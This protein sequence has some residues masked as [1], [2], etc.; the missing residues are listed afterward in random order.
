MCNLILF[1]FGIKFSYSLFKS[2]QV[3]FL[4][5]F[6]AQIVVSKCKLVLAVIQEHGMIYGLKTQGSSAFKF[7]NKRF[8]KCLPTVMYKDEID[9]M[10]SGCEI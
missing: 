5:F 7:L 9:K 2:F 3:C 4:L 6:E 1:V 8:L 10:P